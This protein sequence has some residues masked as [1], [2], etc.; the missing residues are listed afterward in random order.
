MPL[1]AIHIHTL[2]PPVETGFVHLWVIKNI[3]SIN[4]SFSGIIK[5]HHPRYE[6]C[7]LW[8]TKKRKEKQC[9]NVTYLVS[10]GFQNRLWSHISESWS[11][12][13][14]YLS[15][16]R[17]GNYSIPFLCPYKGNTNSTYFDLAAVRVK[18]TNYAKYLSKGEVNIR[19]H[20]HGVTNK[21]YGEISL[22]NK[23]FSPNLLFL[24][25]RKL[26]GASNFISDR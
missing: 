16:A 1:F 26:Q 11:C 14:F 23:W 6:K 7:R 18:C 3:Y 20:C 21:C 8:K 15:M 13:H 25:C 2:S 19:S 9:R 17:Q 22:M 24:N 10:L 4:K 5:R 12:H